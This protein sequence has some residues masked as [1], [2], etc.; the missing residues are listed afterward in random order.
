M[1]TERI[2]YH[3]DGQRGVGFPARAY[4]IVLVAACGTEADTRPE[5]AAYISEAILVPQCGRG[6]CHSADLR[7][8]DLA[9]DSITDSIASLQSFGRQGA[10]MVVRGDAPGS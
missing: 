2:E 8:H 5:T 6:G 9:F 4:L 1:H 7:Q 10:P 3:A